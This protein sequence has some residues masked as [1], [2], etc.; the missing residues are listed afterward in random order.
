MKQSLVDVLVSETLSANRTIEQIR[1]QK[2][3]Q[4]KA[5]SLRRSLSNGSKTSLLSRLQ[6]QKTA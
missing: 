2:V 3:E 6:A 5:D 1:L 4:E